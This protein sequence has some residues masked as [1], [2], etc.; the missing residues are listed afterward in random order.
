MSGTG[1]STSLRNMGRDEIAFV[2]V[3]G[4]PLPFKGGEFEETMTGDSYPAIKR[5][6]KNTTK[7]SI[8]IDDVQYLMG[9]AFMRRISETGWQRF[10]EI[11]HDFNDLLDFVLYELPKNKIVYFLGHTEKDSDGVEKFKT[12][13]KAIDTCICV[14]G[15][16]S[17]VLKTYVNDGQYYFL[18]RNNG[19]DT[20]KAPIDMFPSYAIDNDLKYVDDK[21]RNYYELGDYK[22]DEE[23]ASVDADHMVEDVEE[24][25]KRKPRKTAAE[26]QKEN[27]EKV[28]QYQQARD[29]AVEKKLGDR[30]EMEFEE[31]KEATESI[32]QP[33]LEKVPRRT[34]KE[35]DVVPTEPPTE[36]APTEGFMNPTRR[37][38]RTR[39]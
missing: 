39:S 36:P 8:V 18:T 21:I 5:F 11:A 20:T 17:I 10:N 4:K 34:R 16:T 29:I 12:M 6:I 19:R 22:P 37:T 23:M 2:N 15:K 38:R 7:G 25:P 35:R 3:C 24:K 14:E 9:N 13:G 27:D 28:V 31:Y 33:K 30:D 26:V 32:P 1:K